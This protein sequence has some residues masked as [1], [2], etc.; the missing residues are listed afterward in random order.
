MPHIT[1]KAF[2]ALQVQLGIQQGAK[3]LESNEAYDAFLRGRFLIN[4]HADYEG[5][6]HWFATATELNP[7]FADAW[8]M[9]A[10]VSA[11]RSAFGLAPNH[12]ENA[13][14]RREFTTRALAADPDNPIALGTRALMDTHYREK[15]TQAR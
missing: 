13:T 2:G 4:D 7:D 15:T 12:G 8:A 1:S 10:L 5:A 6:D 9:R 3:L 14:Q 11:Y